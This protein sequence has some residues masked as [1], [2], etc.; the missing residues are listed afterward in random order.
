MGGSVGSECVETPASYF[1]VYYFSFYILCRMCLFWE[2]HN[3]MTVIYHYQPLYHL[4]NKRPL[5][6]SLSF[7]PSQSGSQIS[8]LVPPPASGQ[9]VSK[10]KSWSAMAFW[11][12]CVW[13]PRAEKGAHAH[14]WRH[15]ERR[16]V[17]FAQSRSSHTHARTHTHRHTQA[18]KS[19]INCQHYTYINSTGVMRIYGSSS[20]NNMKRVNVG[21]SYKQIKGERIWCH[22]TLKWK[23]G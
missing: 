4:V 21:L 22:V 20:S 15:R 10:A 7:P 6:F 3:K 8:V 17:K 23:L 16:R 11:L 12:N 13:R 5:T 19:R 9:A 18:N 2:F 14:Y 1:P